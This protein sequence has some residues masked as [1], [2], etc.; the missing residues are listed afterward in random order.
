MG[1]PCLSLI[2]CSEMPQILLVTGGFLHD[3]SGSR[4]TFWNAFS[5]ST[6]S[7]LSMVFESIC[8][9]SKSFQRSM[10]Q[11]STSFFNNNASGTPMGWTPASTSMPLASV[12]RHP[13][14]QSRT[15]AFRFRTRALFLYWT[16]SGISIFF[17][18]V[19]HW[20]DAGRSGILKICIKGGARGSSIKVQH[21][22]EDVAQ[23][24]CA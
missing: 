16:G 15:G 17:I 13:S 3:H 20:P 7:D 4:A 2:G 14:S 19:P 18:P 8:I 6:H 9:I 1:S 5:K 11:L 21:S 12:I 10:S 23:V 22:S 24:S